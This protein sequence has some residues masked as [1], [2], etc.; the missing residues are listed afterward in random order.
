MSSPSPLCDSTSYSMTSPCF[1]S[2]SGLASQSKIIM[3][4]ARTWHF[5]WHR[6]DQLGQEVNHQQRQ[7]IQLVFRIK[8]PVLVPDHILWYFINKP[9]QCTK[10]KGFQVQVQHGYGEAPY[11][12]RKLLIQLLA[13]EIPN[14]INPDVGQY[15]PKLRSEKTASESGQLGSKEPKILRVSI[16]VL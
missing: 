3:L 7:R 15:G 1:C 11:G 13:Q 10:V 2:S 4:D 12:G 5:T 14:L 9:L 16:I 6:T 8:H